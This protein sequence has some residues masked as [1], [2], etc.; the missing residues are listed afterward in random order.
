MKWGTTKGEEEGGGRG[1]GSWRDRRSL[2]DV[3]RSVNHEGHV[4]QIGVGEGE[5]GGERIHQSVGI[6]MLSLAKVCF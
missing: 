1:G 5:G 3:L 6:V 2:L 4:R